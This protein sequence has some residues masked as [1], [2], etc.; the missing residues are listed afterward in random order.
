MDGSSLQTHSSARNN[1]KGVIPAF[2]LPMIALLLLLAIAAII[3][4]GAC[5]AMN[6]SGLSTNFDASGIND[7]TA[8]GSANQAAGEPA[9]VTFAAVGDNLIHGAVYTAA[10]TSDGY[11]FTDM[12]APCKS[13]IEGVDI[14]YINS[15]TICAGEQFGLQSYPMFNGP[16]EVLDA[17]AWA[18]FDWISTASN[19]AMDMGEEGILA[20]LEH[21]GTLPLV[22]TGTHESQA[23][24]DTPTTIERNGVVFGLASF[25]YGLNGMVEPDGKDY[26]IDDIDYDLMTAQIARLKEVADVLIVSIH[27]GEEYV[28]EP[29]SQQL[30]VA[31]FLADQGVSVVI[32]T[33]PHVINPTRMI[34]GANGNQTLV[35]YS[36]G[37]FLSAQ[38]DPPRMLGEMA[39]WTITYDRATQAIGIE[40]VE[41][42]PTVTHIE[43]GYSG[44]ACY[45][46]KDYTQEQAAGHVLADVGLSREQL[47]ALATEVFGDEFPVVM[48]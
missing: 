7:N 38:D 41:L 25:T 9:R 11:D 13:Y 42:W 20:Q 6:N 26:L 37:N 19:H 30:E 1:D 39:R 40:E 10:Q 34:T 45:A 46:L 23:A 36:L 22:Q 43:P 5:S 4:F 33:H 27:A 28:Y 18:G 12:Y 2:L 15:E 14:A 31:Q 29:N 17:V 48:G 16:T 44:F 32:G 3:A 24:A 47:C 21:I 8:G 35:I